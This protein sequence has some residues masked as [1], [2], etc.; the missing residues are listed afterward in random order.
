MIKQIIALTGP[1]RAGK[2][3]VLGLLEE[4]GYKGYKFSNA[5]NKEIKRRGK[6]I[7]RKLQQDIGDELRKKFGG[8]YW[9]KEILKI[10]ENDKSELVVIDG[11][12][13][14]CEVKY[15]RDRGAL[16]IGID[17]DYKIRKIRF[18]ANSKPSDPKNEKDFDKIDRRDRG[19]DEE[20]F[21][22]QVTKS[23]E[24]SDVVIINNW[25]SV[26]LLKK[27]FTKLLK[28]HKVI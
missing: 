5:I 10:A 20:D 7:E 28:K 27:A 23:L 17:A 14:S 26:D 9:A 13:N 6:K 24:L 21:G 15:L 11:V 1:I 18:F 19:I 22:Q 2:S 12:R 16:M 4:K 3:L 8:D 25:D